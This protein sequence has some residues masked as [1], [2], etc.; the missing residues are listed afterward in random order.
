MR[1]DDFDQDSDLREADELLR[2][3]DALLSRGRAGS[4][5]GIEDDD[6]PL[7]TE[8]IPAVGLCAPAPKTMPEPDLEPDTEMT[9]QLIDLDT[10]IQR[11]IEAWMAHEMPEIIERELEL[12]QERIRAEVMASMRVGLLPRLS[13]EIASRLPGA[14]RPVRRR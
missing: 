7:V 14:E 3:A 13:E 11:E 5:M 9:E 10:A 12:L 2:K 1:K 8:I 6:L 4:G